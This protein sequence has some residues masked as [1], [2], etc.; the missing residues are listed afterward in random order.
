MT[1]AA[2][3]SLFTCFKCEKD[4]KLRIHLRAHE[5]K[6]NVKKDLFSIKE[7]PTCDKNSFINILNLKHKIKSKDNVTEPQKCTYNL[8]DGVIVIDDEDEDLVDV[9]TKKSDKKQFLLPKGKKVFTKKKMRLNGLKKVMD[10]DCTSYLGQLID[11]KR[12]AIKTYINKICIAKDYEKWCNKKVHIEEEELLPKSRLE[13][14]KR[15]RT[16]RSVLRSSSGLL[17]KCFVKL[18]HIDKSEEYA[19]YINKKE[20]SKKL[21]KN[22]IKFIYSLAPRS[23]EYPKAP[24]AKEEEDCYVYKYD[25]SSKTN[26]TNLVCNSSLN[27]ST[28]PFSVT[29]HLCQSKIFDTTSS[30]E[31]VKTHYLLE[32]NISNFTLEETITNKGKVWKL[33]EIKKSKQPP[34]IPKFP[35]G[36]SRNLIFHPQVI[37]NLANIPSIHLQTNI[38]SNSFYNQH[39]K[40]A[41]HFFY[42]DVICID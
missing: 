35:I 42:S 38:Y 24:A 21:N 22:L 37:D 5:K 41:D 9:S 26:I 14:L 33:V 19:K 11:Y 25:P 29:C 31:N 20:E 8:R 4:F 13:Y 39:K 1:S 10:V 40:K 23:P 3:P 18:H 34:E 6:C 36:P 28:S 17:N 7:S 15:D 12:S 16:F 27:S 32:H 2:N 30:H